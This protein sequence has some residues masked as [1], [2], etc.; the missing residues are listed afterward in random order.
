ML[1]RGAELLKF[2]FP[3]MDAAF[4]ASLLRGL[5]AAVVLSAAVLF[6]NL[7]LRRIAPDDEV[8]PP[9]E[10]PLKASPRLSGRTPRARHKQGNF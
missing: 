2:P 3:T 6:A 1:D 5:M 7:L 10:G 8:S 4:L 9:A